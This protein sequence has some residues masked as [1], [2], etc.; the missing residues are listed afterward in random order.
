V[1]GSV[2]TINVGSVALPSSQGEFCGGLSADSTLMQIG[3]A[4]GGSLTVTS[5]SFSGSTGT[6]QARV[7]GSNGYDSFDLPLTVT[8]SFQ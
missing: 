5:C 3:A 6:V 1:P 7:S 2:S 4:Y 8:Y